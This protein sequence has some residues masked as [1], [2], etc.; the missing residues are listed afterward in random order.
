MHRAHLAALAEMDSSLVP[1]LVGTFLS[2]HSP[3]FRHLYSVR[4]RQIS[5]I[6]CLGSQRHPILVETVLSSDCSKCNPI[7]PT[8]LTI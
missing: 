2:A 4:M 5:T 7:P 3:T 1:E 8:L 6:G